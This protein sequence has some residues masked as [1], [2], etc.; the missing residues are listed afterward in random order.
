MFHINCLIVLILNYQCNCITKNTS[1]Y[2]LKN[3]NP[4][5]IISKI[6]VQSND[7]MIDLTYSEHSIQNRINLKCKNKICS[8]INFEIKQKTNRL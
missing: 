8:N 5:S 3:S 6:Y 2:Q 1:Y 7:I 4:N